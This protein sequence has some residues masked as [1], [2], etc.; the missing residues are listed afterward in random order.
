MDIDT[1]KLRLD[2]QEL[3]LNKGTSRSG[4]FQDIN[5]LMK[6]EKNLESWSNEILQY[7][8]KKELMPLFKDL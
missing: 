7:G 1:L 3:I 6:L 5:D 2:K 8:F 4:R